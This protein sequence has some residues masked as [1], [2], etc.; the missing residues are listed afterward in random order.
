MPWEKSFDRQEALHEA[1]LLFWRQG[2]EDTSISDI[3]EVTGASRYGLYDEF[4]DKH[5][6]YLEALEH[7]G[8]ILIAQ[9]IGPLERSDAALPELLGYRDRLLASVDT[10]I[11][12]LGC[13]LCLSGVDL[14]PSDPEVSA[15]VAA[16][17]QRVIAAVT[18][19]FENAEA[20]GDWQSQ[21][22]P[23]EAAEVI[24]AAV[25]GAA[26]FLRSGRDPA[27]VA[28]GLKNSFAAVLR[29]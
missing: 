12:R 13:F 3:A 27:A 2:Y 17:F 1:M 7:Y 11:G 14:G 18:R 4:G 26:V 20:E 8:E 10:E 23:Q 24:A 19:A 22:S 6:L 16:T 28:R 5:A 15:R 21:L 25:Q 9:L 29:G